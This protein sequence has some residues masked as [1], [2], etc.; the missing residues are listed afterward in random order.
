M[1]A[2]KDNTMYTIHKRSDKLQSEW[3]LFNIDWA[4]VELYHGEQ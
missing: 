3:L 1:P 4:I 2:R